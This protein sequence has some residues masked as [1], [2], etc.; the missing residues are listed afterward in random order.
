MNVVAQA[1]EYLGGSMTIY[2]EPS[3]R[4]EFII[5][6]PVSLSIIYTITF[7]IGKYTIS[8][9]TS[10]IESID[11]MEYISPEDSNSF[12]DLRGGVVRC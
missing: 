3:K 6:L 8:I 5:K 4:T 12:Y 11:R 2:S 1:I 10:N 9:P 7:K